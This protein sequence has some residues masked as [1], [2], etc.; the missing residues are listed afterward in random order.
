[1]KLTVSSKALIYSNRYKLWIFYPSKRGYAP[2]S[3]TFEIGLT[4]VWIYVVI[5]CFGFKFYIDK[6]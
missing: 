5:I 2:L 4:A 6:P 3:F 1:M